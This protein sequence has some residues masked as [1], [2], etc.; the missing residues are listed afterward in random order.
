VAIEL[1]HSDMA[2]RAMILPGISRPEGKWVEFHADDMPGAYRT[3]RA[4]V[5]LAK[6]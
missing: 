4:V 6:G 5:A 1:T 2:D 3:F